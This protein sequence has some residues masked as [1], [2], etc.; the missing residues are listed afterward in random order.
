MRIYRISVYL[1]LIAFAVAFSYSFG[2]VAA[3]YRFKDKIELYGSPKT[4][5]SLEGGLL[6]GQGFNLARFLEINQ[7]GV[8]FG[9]YMGAARG[10]LIVQLLT[11]IEPPK[12]IAE[13]AKRRIVDF[14]VDVRQLEDNKIHY[15][16]LPR[17]LRSTPE[18]YYLLIRPIHAV[19]GDLPVIWLDNYKSFPGPRADVISPQPDGTLTTSPASGHFYLSPPS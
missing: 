8:G 1:G 15:L 3:E 4:P 2:K 13:T 11:G 17:G 10:R 12:T 9:T 18:G 19:G 7:V 14:S 5:A 6:L 16:I